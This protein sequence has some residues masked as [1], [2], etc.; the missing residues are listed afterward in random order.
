MSCSAPTGTRAAKRV[1]KAAVTTASP[2]ATSRLASFVLWL[3]GSRSD[4]PTSAAP[5]ANRNARPRDMVARGVPFSP[6]RRGESNGRP[7]GAV[8][9]LELL[10]R[11][12]PAR[13]VAADLLVLV[14]PAL[15]DDR[16]RLL[17][18]IGLCVADSRARGRRG[19]GAGLR[20]A[21]AARV[22][23]LT[24]AAGA[25]GR[26][27]LPR[28]VAAGALHL[29]LDVE[30]HA[31]KVRPD[32]VHQVAEQLERLVLVGDQRI[33]LGEPAQ[34]DALAQVVHVVQVLAPALVDDLQQQVALERAH[35]LV[36]E[37]GL[38]PVVQRDR[39]ARERI[40]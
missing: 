28:A 40:G 33:D 17:L 22:R 23:D 8:A 5:A 3:C 15:L 16:H 31:R 25:V 29:D 21:R 9:L 32:G 10:A 19:E 20:G 13:V 14:H 26:V 38:A 27:V 1:R 36:A 11:P 34:V 35:Q 37:L 6:M 18:V 12:A 30:D 39:L 4:T 24:G 2:T 7:L